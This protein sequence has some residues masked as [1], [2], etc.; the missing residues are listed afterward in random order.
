M[1]FAEKHIRHFENSASPEFCKEIIKRYEQDFYFERE[2]TC[3]NKTVL[4]AD[5]PMTHAL[6]EIGW[7][8][9]EAYFDKYLFEEF[10]DCYILDHMVYSC[11]EVGSYYKTHT[12]S[13]F[14]DG[15]VRTFSCILYLNDDFEGGE[16]IFPRDELIY[17]PVQGS[18]AIFPTGFTLPHAVGIATNRRHTIAY[19]FYK[20]VD[21]NEIHFNKELHLDGLDIKAD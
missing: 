14:E 7:K 15:K 11:Y 13:N 3:P 4:P 12:D 2:G 18:M 19:F 20:V 21:H 16:L 8:N 1:S 5:D 10:K 9:A 6:A 17:K